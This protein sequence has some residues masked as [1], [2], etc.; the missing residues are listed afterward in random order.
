MHGLCHGPDR[1]RHR[2]AGGSPVIRSRTGVRHRHP[3]A[4]HPDAGELTETGIAAELTRNPR[5]SAMLALL[6]K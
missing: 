5:S 1:P 6:S 3:I 4:P 2:P